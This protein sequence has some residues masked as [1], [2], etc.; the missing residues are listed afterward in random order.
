MLS[1][2]SKN[3]SVPKSNPTVASKESTSDRPILETQM[4]KT[5]S[6]KGHPDASE[7]VLAAL[8]DVTKQVFASLP[9]DGAMSPDG[10]ALEGVSIGEVIT[11]LTLLELSGLVTSL[12]GG[13]YQ[14]K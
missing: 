5:E 7:P 8:D 2:I 3:A 11:A 14:R 13:L 12:P 10:I 4:S 9:M 1:A 6:S